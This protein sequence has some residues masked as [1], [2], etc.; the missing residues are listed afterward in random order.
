MAIS[1][2]FINWNNTKWKLDELLP[3][4]D[5]DSLYKHISFEKE[6]DDLMQEMMGHTFLV[7][8][9]VSVDEYESW[10]AWFFE[11]LSDFVKRVD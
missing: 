7:F 6:L 1:S 4:L 9:S 8:K 5:E 3:L 10:R 2:F 11:E